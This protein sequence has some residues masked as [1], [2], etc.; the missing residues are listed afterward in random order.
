[1]T[2]QLLTKLLND[3]INIS[4]YLWHI[5]TL[6]SKARNF[7][8]RVIPMRLATVLIKK[9]GISIHILTKNNNFAIILPY[10]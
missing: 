10:N 2:E 1:M 6:G 7:P 3:M 9:S 4:I 8:F 5:C